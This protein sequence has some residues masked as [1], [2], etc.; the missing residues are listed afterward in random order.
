[1][2]ISKKDQ[3]QTAGD[4]AVQTQI[5]TQNNYNVTHIYNIIQPTTED[6]IAN[7]TEENWR[8]ELTIEGCNTSL[9]K[10]TLGKEDKNVEPL[11]ESY[12]DARKNAEFLLDK[13]RKDFPNLTVHDITHVDSLWNVAD[14]I[15]GDEYKINPLEG[16]ILGIAFLIHGA[17]LSY[18]AV[19]GK[20]KLR[21]TI[22][23]NDAYADGLGDMDEEDFKIECDFAAIRALHAKYAEDILNKKF[24]RNNTTTFYIIDNDEYRN[25]FGDMIGKIAAS[26]HWSIDEVKSKLAIQINPAGGFPNNWEINEQKLACIL[27]CA[28]A[29]HIDNGCAPFGIYNSLIVNGVSREHWKSQTHLGQ[30]KEN[31]KNP[32][33]L[34]ITST[35]LFTKDNFAAWNVAY[36]AVRLFDEEL[37]KSNELLK[38]EGLSF[39]H[40]GV[41]GAESKEA[42][43]EYIKTDGWQPCSFGVH[44]SNV[45]ALIENLGGS[46]L[47]G[48][49]NLLLVTLR[50]LIQNSRD[51]ILARRTIDE[52]FEEGRITIRFIEGEGK[53]L[54]EVHD[55]GIGMSLN[56]I[57][58]H[59]LDFGSSYWRSDT[60]K[61]EYLGL[62]SKGFNPIGKYG[63]GFYS[64]FMVAT[65]VEVITRKYTDGAKSNKIEFPEGLTLSPIRSSIDQSTSVSTI[66][67]FELNDSI[68][69]EY[70]I[71]ENTFIPLQKAISL[72]TAGLD[73]DVYYECSNERCMV[74]ENIKSPHFDKAKWLEGL[75]VNCP[76]NINDLASN[77]EILKDEMGE[78]RGLILPPEFISQ[79]VFPSEDFLKHLPC[80]K[81]IGGLLSSSSLSSC[82]MDNGYIG[83]LDGFECD[84]SRNKM[85]LDNP[86]KQ[87]LQEWAKKKYR[88]IHYELFYNDF[89]DLSYY[90]YKLI[91]FCGIDDEIIKDNTRCFFSSE[92]YI[93]MNNM[94]GTMKCLMKIHL[95]LTT[96]ID[97]F[98]GKFSYTNDRIVN[99]YSYQIDELFDNPNSNFDDVYK[100]LESTG[101]RF[102]KECVK[103]FMLLYVNRMPITTYEEI[104][105]KFCMLYLTH[106][107][108]NSNFATLC[109]WVNLLLNRL[110]NQMI[111]WN[112]VDDNIIRSKIKD[113]YS[114]VYYYLYQTLEEKRKESIFM[115]KNVK[116]NIWSTSIK[117][118]KPC[119]DDV[120]IYLNN[121]IV[122]TSDY[123]A[124][125]TAP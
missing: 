36:D 34:L 106:P 10:G 32:E 16:Y 97:K 123:L 86:L 81:T 43:S 85:S 125:I 118:T 21:E 24:E 80:F 63:I 53:R 109:V 15:V 92:Q 124:K 105:D 74:H 6:V 84:I 88:K 30:V 39:P 64:I 90:Y 60:V 83:F 113:Y 44:S 119:Y 11:R 49:D 2:D 26:H 66:V 14:V 57:K 77:I 67:R 100:T 7:A 104:I 9:W 122:P 45:R 56:C 117:E 116:K 120:I 23:W 3:K 33:Q 99:E 75:F 110:N 54:I 79:I 5:E 13:I 8:E 111:D 42:L 48:K 70:K 108:R 20:D 78:T 40:I 71:G 50:E 19:R 35:R 41:T 62:R 22:E 94:V 82:F 12:L 69:F 107:F 96:G 46:K 115:K 68:Q 65:S 76:D 59:L 37:K 73:V 51:A 121:F 25:Q 47:Y 95:Y 114:D 17:A 31:R 89:G 29:G 18:D 55:N 61:S 27:R 72:L 38:S 112:R 103:I 91:K 98:A 58:D 28:D 52:Q 1:M 93:L 4:N 102:K 101:L 87:C